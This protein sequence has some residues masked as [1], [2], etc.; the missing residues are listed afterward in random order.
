MTD[1]T[2]ESRTPASSADHPVDP[3]RPE[4]APVT[5]RLQAWMLDWLF[6]GLGWILIAIF[7]PGPIAGSIFLPDL[8]SEWSLLLWLFGYRPVSTLLWHGTPAKRLLGIYVGDRAGY[9][10]PPSACSAASCH[11]WPSA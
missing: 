11:S 3:D 7:S 5:R 10:C 4:P 2:P 8:L 9:P 6:I 1:L